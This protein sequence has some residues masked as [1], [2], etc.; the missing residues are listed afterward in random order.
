MASSPTEN[1]YGADS[2]KV[3]K[4]LDAVRKR[5]GM[6]IG[7]TDDGSGLHHMVFEV[8]D[9]AIDEA[10]AGHCD[11]ILITLNADGSVSVEDNG[12]GIPTGIHA[13]EGVSAAEV[14]M[15]QLHAGGKFENTSDDNAYKVS[16]GLHGVGVSVVNAL[17]EFLDL[18]IWRDGEEHWMRF[19]HGDAEAPL[20]VLGP[21]PEGKK[22]TRVTFLPSPA[23]FKITEFD[24][25]KLEH[26]Y[27]ELAFLNSGVR[28]FLT[29][30]R[31]EEE[32]QVELFYEG[33]IAAF[34]RYLDRA[35]TPLIPEPIS[36]SGQ[37]DD[38]G[39]D[40]ALE[41]N[42]SYYEQVLAFT[43][44]I[45]QRD[46]GTHMAAFRAALTRTL[47]N[48]ADKSGMMKREKVSL[49]G[50]DMREGLTAIVSVKLPDP[51]FSSQTKDK[52]V[53]SE[54]RQPLESL[55]ADKLAEWLEENPGHA[56]TIIQKI[57]DAA[58]A[59]E[60]ARKAR[61]A[62]RKSVMGIASL[63]GKLADCQERDPAKSE[64]FLVEGDSA[65]GSAKQGR[66]RHNQ[67]ILPLKGKILNVERARFDRMLSSKEVG[68]LI[69]AIGTGIG[70]DDFNIDKL[71][72]HK[73]VIMTDADVDGAHIRTL[74]LTFFY[75]QMPEIIERGHL[76]IA[77]PPLYKVAKGRSE[78]YLK[79]DA[80]LDEYLVGAGL[81]A[82]VLETAEGPRSGEDLRALAEHARRMRTLMRYVPRR[83]DPAIIEALALSGALDPEMRT[84]DRGAA[85]TRAAA[86]LDAGD[87]EGSWAGE[88]S[89]EGSYTLKRLWRG[90]TDW[91][92][93]DHKFLV[94]AEARKLHGLATE[95]AE[96]Y[97]KPSRLIRAGQA[98]AAEE[99]DEDAIPAKGTPVTR[100]SELLDAILAAGRKGLSVQ[101][102]KGL[103]EMNAEQLW[104]TT[105]DPGNRSLLQVGVDQADV[106]DEIFTR[107]M[108]DVVEP[109]RDFIQ[110]N[111]LNVA[112]LDV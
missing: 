40:V 23:T 51:K 9:N 97:T 6:Y 79:D 80:A 18:N 19:R 28:L 56:R 21:A 75:R 15:T 62:S 83:Y 111:A 39:I 104:E 22:G 45:P 42:D 29:D 101:R 8:S 99:G 82:M 90:V 5:P 76:F 105:L 57:I 54:V 86:W 103:G 38:I 64:L 25:D 106:A 93:I 63:P 92:I 14:I 94:S 88:A 58:A 102:Y 100:P 60:A 69:Q 73:I 109:R 10:L 107:L 61:E 46:G 35:K 89:E 66:N 30:A 71:R 50:D 26:R 37:R 67:A 55:M 24:F 96:S 34:V 95:Q 11:R 87:E 72:Y 27:R 12:R 78:V 70:R 59:R 48:Y 81:G 77:Q 91:H 53:S 108:G 84:A 43:N 31:H 3:L 13:E 17:S 36:V 112:N 4:G 7:D 110:E 2:I 16:G 44:N 1:S 52:L 41:W 65:G 20:K 98:E 32:R 33:G 49:T 85:I 47:N 74:L 68:T